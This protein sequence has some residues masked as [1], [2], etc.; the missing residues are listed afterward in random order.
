MALLLLSWR[1]GGASQLTHHVFYAFLMFSQ[2]IC[3]GTTWMWCAWIESSGRLWSSICF[4]SISAIQRIWLTVDV[5]ICFRCK[6]Y[7]WNLCEIR[8]CDMFTIIYPPADRRVLWTCPS[9]INDYQLCVWII[10]LLQQIASREHFIVK[11]LC[12]ERGADICLSS[13]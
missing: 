8:I 1:W 10:M 6:F 11:P 13:V 4:M 5:F 2:D 12:S 7:C 3:T 9:W